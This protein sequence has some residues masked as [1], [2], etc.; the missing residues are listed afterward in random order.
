MINRLVNQKKRNER[1]AETYGKKEYT[2]LYNRICFIH[3]C[4]ATTPF[5]KEIQND[6]NVYNSC[7]GEAFKRHKRVKADKKYRTLLSESKSK[8]RDKQLS[9]LRLVYGFSEY[10]LH[11][12]VKAVQSKFKENIGSFEAQKLA[13]RAFQT[14]EKLHY[15]KAKKVHFK[16]FGDDISVENKSNTTGLRYADGH[17][18]WGN[19]PQ[20]K[21]LND[22]IVIFLSATK[23]FTSKIIQLSITPS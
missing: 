12:F 17:I 20:R 6:W 10:A 16:A 1:G 21:L 14:V 22:F 13:T 9:D 8:E 4:L 18:L 15:G 5:G 3:S 11:D 2:H 23:F 7:L 19:R